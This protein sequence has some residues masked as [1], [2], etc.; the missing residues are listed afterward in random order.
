MNVFLVCSRSSYDKVP[1]VREVLVGAGHR[2]TLPNNFDDPTREEA[3][4]SS[5][6][7]AYAAWKAEMPLCV[8]LR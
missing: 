7:E 4:K 8:N 6:V 1:G 3:M 2:V 5:G